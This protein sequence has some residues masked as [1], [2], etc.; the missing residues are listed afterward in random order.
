MIGRFCLDQLPINCLQ[1][2]IV[3]ES[4]GVAR[5]VLKVIGS[6]APWAIDRSD[7]VTSDTGDTCPGTGITVGIV[8]GIIEVAGKEWHLI[9]A[10]STQTGD[11]DLSVSFL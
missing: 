4:K 8:G 10:G 2:V 5:R 3:A 6:I 9:V 1:Q 7:G 11:P